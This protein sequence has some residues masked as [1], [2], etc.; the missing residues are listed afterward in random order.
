MRKPVLLVLGL[1]F[2]AGFAAGD[3]E[4]PHNEPVEITSTGETT[5][6]NGFATARD[7]VA[8][9]V[10]DT[11]IYSDHAIYN[12]RTHDITVDGNVRIYRATTMYLTEHAIYNTDTK[13]IKAAQMQTDYEPY[14][15][16]GQNVTSIGPNAY[17]IEEGNFTTHDTPDPSF[18]LHARTIRVY[19]NDHV[20]FHN[21]T[22]YIGHVPILWWPYVYQSL[23]DAFSFS[24][25]P[26]FLTSWGASL[27]TKVNF[28][29]TKNLNGVVHVDY[30]SR[31]GVALGFDANL[32]YG[33]DDDSWAKL[34]TY[35]LQ[36]QNPLINRTAIPRGLVSTGRYRVSLEDMTNFTDDI[37]GIVDVTKLSDPYVMQDFY[38]NE[39]RIDPVPD[40]VVAITKTAPNWTLT[41]TARFQ[42]NEFFEQTERLPELAFDVNRTPILN[43]P[44]FYESN[45]SF[46]DLH[47]QFAENSGF[48][49]YST[50]RFD[51][52]HQLTFPDTYFG[53]LSIVPRAGI[54]ET[55]YGRTRDLGSTISPARRES[56]RPDFYP[57]RSDHAKSAYLWR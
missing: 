52:F 31:R 55:Y 29:I 22:F 30:R 48:E 35:Y 25:S 11:D 45:T 33:K 5:Y 49:N 20:V 17:R 27:L 26:A 6:E 38:Q 46:A 42:A 56:A 40:D 54:R 57:T 43:G 34:K 50:T 4:T 2:S 44:I 7:D 19:E 32:T 51:T 1:L 3:I 14:F 47:R 13:E 9:H 24:V 10:G 12:T 36:D 53:W 21:V 15:V 39:F 23:N 18:H 41:G 28:P 16:D 37:Y 8:I